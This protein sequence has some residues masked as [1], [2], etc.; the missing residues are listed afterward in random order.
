ML[1]RLLRT[2]QRFRELPSRIDALGFDYSA[3]ERSSLIM[4]FGNPAAISRSKLVRR[5]QSC[6]RSTQTRSNQN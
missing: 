6:G 5:R 1:N 4:T 2:I 3:F